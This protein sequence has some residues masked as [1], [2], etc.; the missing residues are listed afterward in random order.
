M[1]YI[2]PERLATLNDE[3]RALE[4]LVERKKEDIAEAEHDSWLEQA[5]S[6]SLSSQT[7]ITELL[8]ASMRKPNG[9]ADTVLTDLFR[10]SFPSGAFTY[11]KAGFSTDQEG[12]GYFSATLN[13]TALT[14]NFDAVKQEV[15]KF[16]T[17]APKGLQ[18]YFLLKIAD[19]DVEISSPQAGTYATRV[20]WGQTPVEQ[21]LHEILTAARIHA[22]THR[23]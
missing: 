1:K 4:Q 3:L 15:Q 22:L 18:G 11:N 13:A 10:E 12:H 2:R 23:S 7:D 5:H 16:F 14:S 20:R 6:Y 8:Y 21:D 19:S 9:G 17:H